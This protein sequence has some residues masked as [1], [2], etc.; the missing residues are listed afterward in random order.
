VAYYRAGDKDIGKGR[1]L[2]NFIVPMY[3][4]KW[5]TFRTVSKY[6]EEMETNGTGTAVAVSIL[7]VKGPSVWIGDETPDPLE[8]WCFTHY[9]IDGHHKLQAAY[10]AGRSLRLLS[11]IAL[12]QGVAERPQVEEALRMLTESE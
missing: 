7:D 5:L 12:S 4:T 3:P 10:E 6:R 11:F 1:R 9:L 2:F 8:H